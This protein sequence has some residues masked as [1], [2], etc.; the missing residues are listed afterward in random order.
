MDID[1][2]GRGVVAGVLVGQVDDKTGL[3]FRMGLIAAAGSL[4]I[5]VLVDNWLRWL[6]VLVFLLALGFL[7]AV[8][9]SKRLAKAT[10]SRIAPPAKIDAAQ[11]ATAYEEADLPTGPMALLRL[12]WR[13]RKGVGPEI[14]RLAIVVNGLRSDLD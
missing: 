10:I 5:A 13:L 14:D 12:I 6:A 1:D 2:I 4:A 11:F 3:A 9:I 8:F 7:L